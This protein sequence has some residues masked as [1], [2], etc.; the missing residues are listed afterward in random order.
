MWHRVDGHGSWP[1]VWCVW[2]VM[3]RVECIRMWYTM[4]QAGGRCV[5]LIV[6]VMCRCDGEMDIVW[7]LGWPHGPCGDCVSYTL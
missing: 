3:H 4:T 5:G 1:C 7:C 6:R 2:W